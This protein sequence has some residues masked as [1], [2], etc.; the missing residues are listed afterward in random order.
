MVD[1][2]GVTGVS[3]VTRLDSDDAWRALRL[4]RDGAL[5]TSEWLTGLALEGRVYVANAGTG[6][7]P[8]SFAALYTNTAPDLDVSVPAG[9]L[10]IPIALHVQIETF[11]S[12]L[13]AEIVAAIGT[14]GVIAPTSAT[15]VTPRNLRADAPYTS[16][17]TIV[18]DGTGATYPTGNVYEFWRD[19]QDKV[20]T[21][22]TAVDTSP[23][24]GCSFRW[25]AFQSGIWPIMYSASAI[26]RLNVFASVQTGTGF[27]TLTYIELPLAAIG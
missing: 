27:I 26:T 12:T 10:V 21:I 13:L 2:R 23:R 16:G 17:C 20:V 15:A 9:T 25:S 24:G 7:A 8:I 5:F 6:T 1:V 3:T 19:G 22:A 11:G 14:G 18:S 4:Q